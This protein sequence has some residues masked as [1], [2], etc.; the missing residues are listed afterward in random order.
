MKGLVSYIV[1]C[2]QIWR[3]SNGSTCGRRRE[4]CR[5]QSI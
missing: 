2:C 5:M 1:H 4:L 3:S